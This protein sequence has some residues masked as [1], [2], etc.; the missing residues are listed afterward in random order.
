MGLGLG[1]R[2]ERCIAWVAGEGV[3]LLE[4]KEEGKW[5]T[6]TCRRSASFMPRESGGGPVHA[7]CLMRRRFLMQACPPSG[8][9]RCMV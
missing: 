1:K 8:S 6:R 9:S 7:P 3:G 4:R 5:A 2:A